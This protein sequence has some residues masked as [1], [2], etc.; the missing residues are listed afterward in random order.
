MPKATSLLPRVQAALRKRIHLAFK[1]AYQAARWGGVDS[2]RILFIVGCM[3]SGTTLMTRLFEADLNCRV[4]GEFSAL[5]NADKVAGTRLNPL[6]DVAAFLRRVPAPLV[7]TKPLVETQNVLTLLNYFPGSKSLFMYRRYADVARSDLVKFGPRNAIENIRPI[8]EGD[9]HNWRSEGASSTVREVV[10]RF[11]SER[12]NPNDAAALFWF[13]RNH[14]YFDLNLAG[15]SDVF[16]CRYEHL[17]QEPE[18][19]MRSIY[20][21]LNQPCPDLAHT[22]EVHSA[23]L[24]KGKDLDISADIRNECERLQA[25]LDSHY[26]LQVRSRGNALGSPELMRECGE[27]MTSA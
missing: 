22:T 12:M 21:F 26:E 1:R 15:H 16:L 8:A 9:R 23:S 19:V 17:V 13:A 7:V 14:L 5:S 6:P 24:Q 10:K 20:E 25:R 4:F 2:R 18:H 27:R 3:R 11:Y